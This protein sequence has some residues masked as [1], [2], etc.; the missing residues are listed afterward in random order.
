MTTTTAQ[1]ADQAPATQAARRLLP[2]GGHGLNLDQHIAVHGPPAY[3]GQSR[4]LIKDIG[5]AGLTGRGGAAFPVHRK[6]AAVFAAGSRP[7]VVA[8]GAEGE[9]ASHKDKTLLTLD[10]H[11]VLDGLQLA[12]E[13]V[14]ARAAYLYVHRDAR[15][16]RRI[17][18]ALAQRRAAG[19]DRVT[20]HII[21]APH[22]FLAG[23]E[24]ALVHRIEGGPAVPRYSPRLVAECGIGGAPTLVQNVE[25]LAHVALIARHGAQWFRQTGTQ[26]EPGTM[27]ATVHMS[28]GQA[29]VVETAPGAA[30][31]HLLNLADKPAQAVLVGGYHGVWLHQ[32]KAATI[33]LT[34]AALAT[35]GAAIGAGVLAALPSDRCGVSET[36]RVLRYLADES[37]GQ[38]GPCLNGLPRI[39]E[40]WSVLAGPGAHPRVRMDLDRWAS[41]LDRRGACHHPD[42]STR[43]AR[44]ALRVFAEELWRHEQGLCTATNGAPFLPLPTTPP[45]ADKDW[46]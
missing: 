31:H 23:Q 26:T 45:L 27:L 37:A 15:L 19:I 46:S 41:L 43:F 36:A 25:T 7:V 29:R 6:M 18:E 24:S 14:H 35:E 1:Q 22:R 2:R 32:A 30:I 17:D 39:A 9:P 38:C 4:L 12:A 20:P 40:A 42:G 8:N 21:Y 3:R 5:D 28:D 16:A 33:P 13:A 10:P 11:L 34:N 44:S